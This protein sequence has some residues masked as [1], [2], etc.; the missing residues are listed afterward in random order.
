MRPG[1]GPER[2][3]DGERGASTSGGVSSAKFDISSVYR[4][5]TMYRP[6]FGQAAVGNK[7]RLYTHQECV[8]ALNEYCATQGLLKEEGSAAG[9]E[10]V[11]VWIRYRKDFSIKRGGGPGTEM[12]LRLVLPRLIKKLQLH[13]KVRTN[14]RTGLE[15]HGR[16]RRC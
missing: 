4:A 2:G 9:P 16:R 11:V 13:T 1:Q 5:S 15:V 10:S 3:G 8:D 12:L 7:D 14:V 6:I